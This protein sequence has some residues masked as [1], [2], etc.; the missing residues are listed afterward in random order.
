VADAAWETRVPLVTG[1]GHQTDTTLIDLVADLRAHTPTD[2][3][4]SVLPDRAA[5]L[6][7]LERRGG[8]LIEAADRALTRRDERLERLSRAR[9]LRSAD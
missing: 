5:H 2:A 4:Q 7:E 3:A 8:Y 6:A 9:V 1:V